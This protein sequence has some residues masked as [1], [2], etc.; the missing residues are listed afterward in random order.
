MAR[1]RSSPGEVST[2]G[3]RFLARVEGRPLPG[4]DELHTIP[5]WRLLGPDETD[6]LAVAAALLFHRPQID[7][8]LD[9]ATMRDIARHVGAALFD[10]ACEVPIDT[11]AAT[12]SGAELPHAGRYRNIGLSLIRR[13]EQGHDPAVSRLLDQATALIATGT[14]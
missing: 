6:R 5:A 14:A 4:F 1:M 3:T 10:A 9:G 2:R 13:A 8:S 11:R 7:R 12:S